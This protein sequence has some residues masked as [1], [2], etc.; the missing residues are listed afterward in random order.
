MILLGLFLGGCV[1]E[2]YQPVQPIFYSHKV[3]AGDNKIPCQ[4][5]H[6]GARRGDAAVIPSVARCMGCH[7]F[8]NATTPD[9]KR[10]QPEID[11]LRS[12][13]AGN[14]TIAW[15]KV[16]DLQ[17]FVRFSHKIHI[18]RGFACQECHGPVQTFTTGTK[19]AWD[20]KLGEAPLTMGWCVTCHERNAP[21]LAADQLKETGLSKSDPKWDQRLAVENTLVLG[22]LKDCLTCHK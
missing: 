15:V 13:A 22:R 12:Y 9:L 4:Y 10:Y 20:N 6:S 18:K 1:G 11:K 17:D 16:N 14:T 3:H 5:C 19:L 21:L 8:I 7:K 2:D